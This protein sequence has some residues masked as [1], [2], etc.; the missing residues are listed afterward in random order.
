MIAIIVGQA[1][2]AAKA[3]IMKV[4]L[5]FAGRRQLQAARKAAEVVVTVRHEYDPYV[6]AARL[7][8]GALTF[9]PSPSQV[10]TLLAPF[11]TDGTRRSE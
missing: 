8:K 6:V 4:L 10:S 5:G 7:T 3:K 1:K 2:R 11:T 9:G